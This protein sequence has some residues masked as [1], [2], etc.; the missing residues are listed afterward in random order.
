[1]K[2]PK[3]P[4]QVDSIADWIGVTVRATSTEWNN[5]YQSLVKAGEIA[6]AAPFVRS[7]QGV[8]CKNC[9]VPNLTWKQTTY[10]WRLIDS[11]SNI[12][13]CRS[14]DPDDNEPF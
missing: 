3:P 5:Y 14:Q 7:P 6:V 11:A 8:V 1:M 4:T 13:S 10:G 12:H 2:K 9:G